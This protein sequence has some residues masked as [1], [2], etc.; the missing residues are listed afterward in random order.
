MKLRKAATSRT[1]KIVLPQNSAGDTIYEAVQ[2]EVAVTAHLELTI[3]T[4][5]DLTTGQDELAC[6]EDVFARVVGERLPEC[7]TSAAIDDDV[8]VGLETKL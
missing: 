2:N 3:L 8:A 7:G 5:Q 6:I 4:V 1:R